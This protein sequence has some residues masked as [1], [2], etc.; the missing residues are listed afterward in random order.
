MLL[1]LTLKF[2]LML[3]MVPGTGVVG[4]KAKKLYRFIDYRLFTLCLKQF[5]FMDVK[6]AAM[7]CIQNCDSK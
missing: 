2:M 3:V 7:Q 6:N 5:C 4:L 1:H